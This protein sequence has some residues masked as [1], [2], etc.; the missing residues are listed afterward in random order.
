MSRITRDRC[1][2]YCPNWCP[3]LCNEN[4]ICRFLLVCV[5]CIIVGLLGMTAS[6]INLNLIG[7]C[8]LVDEPSYINVEDNLYFEVHFEAQ[9]NETCKEI[10]EGEISGFSYSFRNDVTARRIFDDIMGHWNTSTAFVC[11]SAWYI[12]AADEDILVC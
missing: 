3:D 8:M 10:F 6:K 4:D 7:M 1:P 5:I 12:D 2:D 11:T 9:F